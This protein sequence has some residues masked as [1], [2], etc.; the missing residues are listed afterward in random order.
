MRRFDAWI[1]AIVMGLA[2]ISLAVVSLPL[3]FSVLRVSGAY[4]AEMALIIP[5]VVIM[6]G[7]FEVWVPKDAIQRFLGHNAGPKGIALAFLMGTAPTGPLYAA[8]PIGASL[9]KK[10]A[11]TANVMVFLGAWAAT[12][13]PQVTLE[14][15]FLGLDFAFTR[16]A[17]TLVSLVAMGFIGNAILGTSLDQRGGDS[18][19][20]AG[21]DRPD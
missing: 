15:K 6:M 5:A 3:L 21:P 9:L 18:R 11:S 17:L 12:K 8:F 13:V 2:Y 19:E 4:L 20:V 16:F 1:G 7:L 10:G 14:A